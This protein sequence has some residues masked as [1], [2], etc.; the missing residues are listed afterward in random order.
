MR[1]HVSSFHNSDLA[2]LWNSNIFHSAIMPKYKK[3]FIVEYRIPIEVE[4]VDTVQEAVSRAKKIIDRNFGVSPDNWNARVFEY[5]DSHSV[6]GP[7]HEYFYNPNSTV[8]R[9]ITKNIGYHSD[10][11]KKGIDPS[12]GEPTG[13]DK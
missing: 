2:V 11:I 9:E 7:A 10:M 1:S 12:T 8:P 4:D 3:Y 5:S 13:K 6:V